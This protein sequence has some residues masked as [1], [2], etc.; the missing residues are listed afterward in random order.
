MNENEGLCVVA[1]T[2]TNGRGRHGKSFYSPDKTGLYMSILL[3]PELS[4]HD[5]LYITPMAAVAVCQ[6]IEKT[7]QTTCQIKWVN[8]IFLG[9]KKVGGILA[10]ASFNHIND[11][12]DYVI[13]GIGIN[14]EMPDDGFPCEIADIAD[15]LKAKN[16]KDEL[17]NNIIDEVFKLYDK[18]PDTDFLEAYKSHSNLIGKKIT[19]LGDEPYICTVLDIDSQCRLIIENENGNITAL[20]SGEVSIKRI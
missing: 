4:V 12:T 14:L 8:D 20:S 17:M 15:A 18:L 11:K 16:I 19:V 7:C 10:E 6:A 1:D 3:R 2:Q 5:S 9:Q 13:L